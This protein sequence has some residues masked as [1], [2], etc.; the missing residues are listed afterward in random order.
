LKNTNLKEHYT[1]QGLKKCKDKKMTKGSK[2]D[3]V[4]K[5]NMNSL[6][7]SW[8]FCNTQMKVEGPL[9]ILKKY[10]YI[11]LGH[12]CSYLL[13]IFES[14]QIEIDGLLAIYFM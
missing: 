4:Y 3:Q 2:H 13:F 6:C 10:I 5:K 9:F 12:L 7:R 8:I 14:W 1:H 11:C